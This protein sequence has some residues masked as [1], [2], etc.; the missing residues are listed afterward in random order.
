LGSFCRSDT[1]LVAEF[2]IRRFVKP[3]KPTIMQEYLLSHLDRILSL[4]PR[5]QKNGDQLGI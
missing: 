4:N 3:L 2:F 1:T 5:P